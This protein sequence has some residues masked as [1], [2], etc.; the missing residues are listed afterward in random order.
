MN[1]EG[2]RTV[3]RRATET[4]IRLALLAI[5]VLACF[6]V[7]QPFLMPVVWAV[8]IAIAL[9]T[10]YVRLERGLGGRKK[11]AATLFVLGGLAML[12]APTV[13]FVKSAVNGA[14]RFARG[15]AADDLVVPPPPDNVAEWPVVG[16]AIHRTWELAATNLEEALRSMAPFLKNIGQWLLSA[17]ASFGVGVFQFVV[18]IIIAGVFL[19]S[20]DKCIAAA[21]AVAGKVGGE[22]GGELTTLAGAT[23]RSVVKGVLGV[24]V[25]QAALA[26]AGMLAAGI[27]HTGAWT[28]LVL[29]L[30]VA[31]LPAAIVMVPLVFWVFANGSTGMG[32][33]FTVWALFVSVS[34]NL[35]KP[36]LLGRGV[37]VPMLVI[38]IGSIGGMLAWGILGLFVGAVV[39]AV[40]YQLLVAWLAEPDATQTAQR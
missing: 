17:T 13:L 26:G 9:Y 31:Q 28:L 5:L 16:D 7:I 22:R 33:F 38:L 20:A 24:A 6:A 36:L 40:G 11:T 3:M 15:I 23:V 4:G 25:I 14:S 34:D 27:P 37:E 18:A 8:I 29:V 1:P 39:L 19:A 32:I 10:P 2:D 35:V 21:R 30:A 12:I